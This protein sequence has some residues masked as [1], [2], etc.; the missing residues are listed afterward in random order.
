MR[1]VHIK[2]ACGIFKNIMVNQLPDND[3]CDSVAGFKPV[4]VK[5]V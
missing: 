4:E 2:K 1:P 3:S 5:M